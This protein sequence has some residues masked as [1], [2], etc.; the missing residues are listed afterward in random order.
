MRQEQAF[1]KGISV[2]R[3]FQQDLQTIAAQGDCLLPEWICSSM[4]DSVLAANWRPHFYPVLPPS[5][6]TM[7]LQADFSQL[8][9]QC[10]RMRGRYAVLLAHP[11]GHIDPDCANF[12]A[13]LIKESNS[14]CFI[15]WSQSYGMA[16]LDI[17]SAVA[18]YVSFNG[19]KLISHGG[20]MRFSQKNRDSSPFNWTIF[21][22]EA[23]KKYAAMRTYLEDQGLADIICDAQLYA[24]YQSSPMRTVLNWPQLP[25][26]VQRHL[27]RLGMVQPLLSRP[28]IDLPA[29]SAYQQWMDRIMLMFP[30]P[31]DEWKKHA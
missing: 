10:L 14:S 8:H 27:E 5:E 22:L 18:I 29:S 20:A 9:S 4:V 7:V 30:A 2:R 3:F 19:N 12:I 28:C 11:A 16:A 15:D 17:A 23:Q 24:E 13:T 6:A 21:H 1:L 25:K 26:S 31:R